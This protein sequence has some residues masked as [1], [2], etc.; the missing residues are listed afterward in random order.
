MI[1]ENKRILLRMPN[2]LGDSVMASVAFENL[3]KHFPCATF[4]LVGTKASCEIYGRDERV[5]N[6]FIDDTKKQKNRIKATFMLGREIGKHDI[7]VSFNNHFFAALLLFA[8]KTPLRIGYGKNF[9]SFLLNKRVKYIKNIH[10]VVSYLNLIREICGETLLYPTSDTSHIGNL[11]LIAHKIKHFQKDN[12]KRYIGIA[13]GAAYGSAKRWEEQYFI[14]II[15]YF[16]QH[17]FVVFLFGSNNESLESLQ[18][19]MQTYKQTCKIKNPNN[20]INLIGK[21]T[22]HELC[23]YIAMLDLFITN[24]SGP[25]HLAASFNIPIIAMFGP[26]DSK[27]TSPWK[28]NAILLDKNLPCSPCKKRVCPVNH[29]NCMKLITPDEVLESAY[30]L[31]V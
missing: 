26:T 14:E 13:P 5:E 31:L 15:L 2:W 27:E 1:K 29:H 3:K 10:Q 7:A 24:D 4:S 17:D 20:L 28:A 30:K 21:T 18:D 22:I 11:K 9:R 8:T 25:M 19:F 6:I 23:D 12:T 16:L